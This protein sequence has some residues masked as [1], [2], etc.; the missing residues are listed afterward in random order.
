LQDRTRLQHGWATAT[1][2]LADVLSPDIKY[3]GGQEV[4][5]NILARISEVLAKA[6]TLE[7]QHAQIKE[8]V[9]SV[10]IGK[11]ELN[12]EFIKDLEQKNEL[13]AKQISELGGLEEHL[14]QNETVI[15]GV[16][17]DLKSMLQDLCK[18]YT[19]DFEV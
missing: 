8:M 7:M 6:E 12:R 11:E 3:G 13:L 5:K 4:I 18:A 15:A 1:E 17:E 16:R 2:K 19:I 14:R 10:E 9:D